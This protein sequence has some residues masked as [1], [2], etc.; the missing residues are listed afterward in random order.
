MSP[1]EAQL[2][3]EI[4]PH[5][6]RAIEL[7]EQ[8]RE[9]FLNELASTQ[10]RIVLAIRDLL[11]ERAKL[12]TDG[13]LGESL[14]PHVR[15][16]T[17]TG[18][19]VGAY[20]IE[21]L[22][23]RGGMGE[24]WLAARSDG[25]FEGKCALKFLDA[26]VTSPK[27]AD[28]FRREGQLLARLTHPNIARLLDA[29]A[30]EDGRAY[31]ALEYVDGDP[32]DLYCEALPI[33]DRVRLFTDVVAAV[34]HAHSHL[35]IHR[36]IKPSNVLVTRDGHVKLLDFGIAKLLSVDPTE[37]AAAMTRLEDAVLTPKYAAPEQLLGEVPSTATDVYQLGMLLYLLLT[38][39]H[40]LPQTS[41]HTDRLRAALEVTLPRASDAVVGS[42]QKILRGDLDA[43]LGVALR[44]DPAERY[45]TAQ[46]FREELLR[47]LNHQ[48][49]LARSGATWY[50][51]RKFVARHRYSVATSVGA[52]VALCA[53]LAFAVM[54]AREATLQRDAAR[55]E[56][57]RTTATSDFAT[58]LLSV[59]APGS[60]KFTSAELLA[61]SER[62]IEKQ[63]PG[64]NPLKA[65][66]LAALGR[67]YMQSEHWSEAASVL[68]RA[69][70]IADEQ[71][72][73]SLRARAYCPLALMKVMQ[74]DPKRAEALM[75]QAL[76][77]IADRP[78]H[79][80]LR[81][82]CLTRFSEFGYID[83][84]GEAMVRRASEALGLLDTLQDASTVHRIDAQAALAYGYY[85]LRDNSK[86]D[87]AFAKTL[88]SLEAA[89]RD[90]T[91]AAADILNNWS[92]VHYR[93][94]IRKA[95]PLLHRALELRRSIEGSDG[96]VPTLSHNYAGVL[97]KLG[98][99][100]EAVPVFE[101]TIRTAAARQEN[102]IMFDAMMELA[103]VRILS[104][105]LQEAEAQ[106]ARLAPYY[107]HPRFNKN[108]RA[109]LAYYQGHLAEKRADFAAASK[110]YAESVQTFEEMQ[111]KIPMNVY[112]LTGLARCESAAGDLAGAMD[113]AQR[114]WRLAQSFAAPNSPS[115]LVGTA[116]LALGD[117]QRASGSIEASTQSYQE[118][119]HNLEQTLG[120]DHPQSKEARE[121]AAL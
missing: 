75:L 45:A 106:L 59:A 1:E 98:K 22:I 39:S 82:E 24:V 7:D 76:A 48:P 88:A 94:D 27:L 30:T 69:A 52:G 51:I 49:V 47:Y 6:D 11:G 41:S 107:D 12:D 70:Q 118:A 9:S 18:V 40:P 53:A 120:S 86:A 117:Q 46:A 67:Q 79:V 111:E 15:D 100:K 71:D 93:G 116:L 108:R 16:A 102:R 115:Y 101:E 5:L 19:R 110:R 83:G 114:A 29:G 113:A 81:A 32:I 42:T 37:G 64:S 65:D 97:L 20:T 50:R 105:Q 58:F 89:G 87:E 34:A 55:K 61:E 31:L 104:G 3:N 21:R 28:R 54:Q 96:V 95:E 57:A 90:R 33:D 78:E 62:L 73:V 63:F 112:A 72:D 99:L 38:G 25:R 85:L 10:P 56:L 8:E 36:D 60:S 14:F 121:K 44:S 103:E 66:L 23:G 74:G 68:E 17:L 119:L 43:I 77:E 80:Q 35:I 92:L 13:F 4:R 91:L 84:D 26:S 2:W 109:Q